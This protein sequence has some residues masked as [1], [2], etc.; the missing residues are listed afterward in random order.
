MGNPT[1]FINYNRQEKQAE[2]VKKRIKHFKEFHVSLTKDERKEQCSRCMDCG[3]PFC[4]AGMV[5]GDM[6]SGCPLNN[7]IPEWNDLI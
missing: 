5:I 6:V 2:S 7:L 3:V 4:Q 1:G